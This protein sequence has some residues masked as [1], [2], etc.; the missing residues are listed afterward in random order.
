[1]SAHLLLVSFPKKGSVSASSATVQYSVIPE[2]RDPFYQPVGPAKKED[3]I[4]S[5][6]YL[7]QAVKYKSSTTLNC[8]IRGFP[9]TCLIDTGASIS[10][11]CAGLAMALKLDI[12][13]S[14]KLSFTTATGAE[15]STL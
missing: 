8:S 3:A 1:M 2:E 10:A 13:S 14:K 15:A 7:S 12:D 11:I 4:C 6:T 9:T 5:L